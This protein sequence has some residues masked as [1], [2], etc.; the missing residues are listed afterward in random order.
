ML[1]RALTTRER[2]HSSQEAVLA[3]RSCM[4][5]GANGGAIV[6]TLKNFVGGKVAMEKCVEPE[7]ARL[8]QA[9]ETLAGDGGVVDVRVLR[10]FSGG[11]EEVTVVT[12]ARKKS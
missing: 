2:A 4:S 9:A 7:V 6:V 11:K 3:L 1:L 5:G 8:R 10:L 12:S